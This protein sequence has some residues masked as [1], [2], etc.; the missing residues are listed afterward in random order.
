MHASTTPP[1]RSSRT[2]PAVIVPASAPAAQPAAMNP[3]PV[4]PAS[5]RRSASHAMP[6]AAGPLTAKL[7]T[8]ESSIISRMPG[9]ARTYRTPPR[10]ASANDS[11]GVAAAPVETSMAV[12]ASGA[13]VPEPAALPATATA[14]PVISATSAAAIANDA[15][16]TAN[17]VPVPTMAI[18]KPATGG[19]AIDAS[20][21]VPWSRALADGRRSGPT[22]RGRNACWAGRYAAST[23]PNSAPRA[24]STGIEARPVATST[25]ITATIAPRARWAASISVRGD[26]RSAMTPIGT[27]RIAR[28]TPTAIRTVPRARPDPVSEIT[29]HDRATKWN[30]SPRT[31]TA[32]L[33]HRSRKSRMPVARQIGSARTRPADETS[34]VI[35][36]RS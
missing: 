11:G 16:S 8:S 9:S 25:A 21:R 5:N 13:E 29:S 26:R 14:P 36:A 35:R 2:L 6:T 23:A 24:A 1:W 10:S 15:A 4:G 32:S 18:A 19:P 17:A 33:A 31:D 28:G 7:S 34:A 3:S 20:C 12:A 27:S 30:W 22:A